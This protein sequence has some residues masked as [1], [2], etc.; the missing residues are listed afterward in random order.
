MSNAIPVIFFENLPCD[1]ETRVNTLTVRDLDRSRPNNEVSCSLAPNVSSLFALESFGMGTPSSPLQIHIVS[2]VEFDRENLSAVL[3]QGSPSRASHSQSSNIIG[4]DNGASPSGPVEFTVVVV[5]EDRGSPA[6][7]TSAA[8]IVEIGDVNDNAPQFTQ[9]EYRTSVRENSAPGSEL[10]EFGLRASDADVGEN[11]RV[12]YSLDPT[13]RHY[14]SIN[15]KIGRI[16][17]LVHFDREQ[18]Y[19]RLVQSLQFCIL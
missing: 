10:P 9:R 1:T 18:K 2:A 7:R 4:I 6:R 17:T 19:I 12:S 3:T 16:R 5:C 8:A 11:G 14:F 13:G 15:E